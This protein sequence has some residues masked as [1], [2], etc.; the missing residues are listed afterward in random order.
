MAMRKP[1]RDS[2]EEPSSYKPLRGKTAPP[3]GNPMWQKTE[4]NAVPPK[5]KPRIGG[6]P[7]S[8]LKDG[9]R[10]TTP[11]E[12]QKT[13]PKPKELAGPP[14]ISGRPVPSSRLP[15]K[16]TPAERK[17]MVTGKG[18]GSMTR[19]APR[20]GGAASGNAKSTGSASKY[21]RR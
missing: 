1:R 5:G 13:S 17:R 7:A 15:K 2:V 16:P 18:G 12:K 9:L 4:K 19:P 11:A 14:M 21:G 20:A 10:K 3:K 8:G 6:Q